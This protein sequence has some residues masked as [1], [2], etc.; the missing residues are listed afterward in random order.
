MDTTALYGGLTVATTDCSCNCINTVVLPERYQDQLR[1]F[2]AR[3][4]LINKIQNSSTM[5]SHD[6]KIYFKECIDVLIK[7]YSH[8]S[9]IELYKN[10]TAAIGFLNPKEPMQHSAMVNR[11]TININ[12]CLNVDFLNDVY[13]IFI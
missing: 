2:K 12:R 10:I 6:C 3:Y 11:C 9:E 5:D 4:K 7:L 13:D 8:N 1:L